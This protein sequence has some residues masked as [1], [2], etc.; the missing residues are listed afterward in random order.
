[1][2]TNFTRFFIHVGFELN[3][4]YIAS[5]LCE[6]KDKPE[7]NCN[8]KCFLSKKLKQVEEKERKEEQQT[9][10]KMFQESFIVSSVLLFNNNITLI[11]KVSFHENPEA[12]PDGSSDIFHPPPADLS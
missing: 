8:G 11:R 9:Q 10:R 1:M 5:V 4:N 12:L 2:S 7:L 6:N 3:K